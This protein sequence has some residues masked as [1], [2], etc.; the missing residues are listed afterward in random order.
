[1]ISPLNKDVVIIKDYGIN[2]F[3]AGQEM[4][5]YGRLFKKVVIG[6]F[7]LSKG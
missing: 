3:D 7:I 6:L 1:M 5:M 4:L 2:C